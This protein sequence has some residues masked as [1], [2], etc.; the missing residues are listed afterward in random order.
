MTHESE[1]QI[2]ANNNTLESNLETGTVGMG[3][4]IVNYI[5]TQSGKVL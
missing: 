3:H 2:Q 4:C 1:R 5:G